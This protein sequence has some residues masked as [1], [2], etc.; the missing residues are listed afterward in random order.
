MFIVIILLICLQVKNV[1]IYLK[2][3][4]IIINLLA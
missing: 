2:T 1:V 4:Y 3:E